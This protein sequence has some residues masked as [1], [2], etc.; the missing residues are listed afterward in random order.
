MPA[1]PTSPSPHDTSHWPTGVKTISLEKLDLL[2]VDENNYLY[3]DG[4][5]VQ[6]VRRITLTFWQTIGAFIVGIFAIVG[7]IG[8]FAQG[9]A[10]YNDWARRVSWMAAVCQ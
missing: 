1:Q 8:S 10:A 5:R 6:I 3:W 4:K 7:A 9:W 2:G